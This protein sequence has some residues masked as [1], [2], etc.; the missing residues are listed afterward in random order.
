MGF[1]GFIVIVFFV[2]AKRLVLGIA[3]SWWSEK[4]LHISIERGIND[5]FKK[6]SRAYK[7]PQL[8]MHVFQMRARD[9]ALVE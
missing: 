6:L 8:K 1:I 9:A 4:G 2:H 5:G 3:I 7:S